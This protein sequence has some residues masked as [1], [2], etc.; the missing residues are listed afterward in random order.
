VRDETQAEI[1]RVDGVSFGNAAPSLDRVMV[2]TSSGF[3]GGAT[4]DDVRVRQWCGAE[5]GVLF[6]TE[7][8]HPLSAT[9]VVRTVDLPVL[10]QNAPNP[11]NP[12][13]RISYDLARECRVSLTVYDLQGRLVATLVDERQGPG[14]R[15][16]SWNGRDANGR[17]AAT[18]VYLYRLQAGSHSE[19]RRMV[20]LK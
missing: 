14:T 16:T 2:Y 8:I 17:P 10:H 13:T 18:G 4:V 19:T 3:V 1:C 11:L 6:G 9:P 7:E 5:P 15:H 12:S 20:L